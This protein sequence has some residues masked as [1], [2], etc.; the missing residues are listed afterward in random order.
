MESYTAGLDDE[1]RRPLHATADHN[2]IKT[3]GI[4]GFRHAPAGI[5]FTV[6]PCLG[7][8]GKNTIPAGAPNQ[9]VGYGADCKNEAVLGRKRRYPP[10]KVVVKE[11]RG[12]PFATEILGQDP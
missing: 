4:H 3:G 8:F 2:R 5:G 9:A 6:Q 7:G 11:I 12:Q 10:G 1:N